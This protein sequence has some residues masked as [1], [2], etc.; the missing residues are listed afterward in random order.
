[1]KNVDGAKF[2]NGCGAPLY[3]PPKD[4][5]KEWEQRCEKECQQGG[6]APII[7][8]LLIILVGLFVIWEFA[9]KNLPNI[10]AWIIDLPY[11]GIVFLVI[12]LLI[13]LIGVKAI[14]EP[15]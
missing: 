14:T 15:R 6:K 13:I 3:G 2:C 1:M 4:T 7:W 10:P 11:C 8:G 5:G 12:G 9:L